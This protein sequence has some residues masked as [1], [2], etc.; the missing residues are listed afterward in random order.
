[1]EFTLRLPPESFWN[2]GESK[3]FLRAAGRGRVPDDILRMDKHAALFRYML[4]R[5]LAREDAEDVASLLASNDAFADFVQLDA[6]LD[7]LRRAK[8]GELLD[9][10]AE[11]VYILIATARWMRCV[12]AEYRG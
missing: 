6:A 5:A 4:G 3:P 8:A 7:Q 12:A 10:D 11:A 9:R 1:V 2:S